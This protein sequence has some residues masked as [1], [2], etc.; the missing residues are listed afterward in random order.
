MTDP[1]GRSNLSAD[2]HQRTARSSRVADRWRRIR[3]R[4]ELLLPASGTWPRALLLAL[5]GLGVLAVAVAS[6]L[7]AAVLLPLALSLTLA[8]G[9]GL[10]ATFGPD[11]DRTRRERRHAA[12]RRDVL[13]E[14]RRMRAREEL[15]ANL[16]HDLRNPLAIALGFSE[17]AEDEDLSTD[18]R[19]QALSGLRR[20]LWEM[21]Q[22]VEN[23]L[24]GSADDAGALAALEP[25]D[26][27]PL[28]ADL[29]SATRVLL[30][31]RPVTLSGDVEPGLLVLADR[32][33]LL[34][35]L[36]NLLGNACKYT[37]SGEIRLEATLCGRFARIEVRDTGPGIAPD[38]MPYIFDRYR[39]AHRG[40][41][42]GV[43]LGLA[44]AHRLTERM[45]GALEASS[46]L[47]VGSTFVVTLP[48]AEPAERRQSFAA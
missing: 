33:R 20:S 38:A 6:G 29:V 5:G 47:G 37:Q 3:E 13:R 32:Q 24:D 16:S 42:A 1:S 25:V 34:R 43:G 2:Q 19:A 7:P 30:R 14:R 27:E 23:V 22:M 35:V 45:G 41:P 40:G 48:L 15:M 10:L 39:R 44:I 8:V 28:C 46:T 26:L 18:E 4:L 21:S 9:A 11:R 17:M 12:L 31:R 36:G